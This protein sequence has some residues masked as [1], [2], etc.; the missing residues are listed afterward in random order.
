MALS[1]VKQ[2]IVEPFMEGLSMPNEGWREA[3]EVRTDDAPSVKL[4]SM[5]GIGAIPVWDGSSDVDPADVN[6]R[7][8]TTVSYTKYALQVR[9]NKYDLKDVP[10]LL[11]GAVR[12]LGVAIANTYGQIAA[13][14]LSDVFDVTSTAG[15]GVAL[16]DN[17][18]PLAS[19]GVR[20]NELASAFD[21]SSLMAAIN[22]ASLWKSYH[23]Q[24]EDWSGDPMVLVGS[25][26]DTTFRET[27]FEV[28]GSAVSSDQMQVNAA[29]GYNIN[30]LVWAKLTDSTQWFLV[31]K[32]RSPLVYWIRSGAEQNIVVDEDNLGTKITV[33]FGIGTQVRPDPVGI[34]GSDV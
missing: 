32:L 12:K 4:A 19:G 14:R 27:A 11:E 16:V 7:Y 28:L 8:N 10:G 26:A 31:S 20:D 2:T 29:S 17:S 6:D 13:D 23:G 22:L 34:I 24:E 18:H 5:S 30:S 33:D 15:D 21:R 25:P 3:F 9:I 1:E